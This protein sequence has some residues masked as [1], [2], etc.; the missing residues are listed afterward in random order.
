MSDWKPEI[1]KVG[2]VDSLEGSDFLEITTVMGV[3]PTIVRKGQFK[4]GDLAAW[5]PYDS[6]LPNDDR[7]LFL[8][9][10]NIKDKGFDEIPEKYRTLKSRKIRGA[11]SEG[12]LVEAPEGF[13]EGD[14]I[15]DHFKLTKRVYKEEYE[16][17][18]T[19]TGDTEKNPENFELFKYDLDGIAKYGY[20]FD[21]NEEVVVQEKLE[22]SN[23][24]IVWMN[25]RIY[26]RS[27]NLF[28]KDVEGSFWWKPVYDLDLKN[29]L[30]KYPS[31]TLWGE[32]L[33]GIKGYSYNCLIKN[34]IIQ[35][36][37]VVFD[38]WDLKYKK[39]LDWDQVVEICNDLGVETAPILYR[40]PWQG[41]EWLKPMAE[42]QSVIGKC[43]REGVVVRSVPE[44]WHHKLGRKILKLKGHGYKLQKG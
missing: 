8:V 40:G 27:R 10:Q 22:G 7:W 9:P 30:S 13:N 18:N 4:E 34:N 32:N 5:L 35:R 24:S 2:K 41:I 17:D 3:Y 23:C 31:L 39:F 28:K 6:V 19:G 33:G 14:C 26:V 37:F 16:I 21:E 15:I 44:G 43:V 20:V 25:D 36:K 1:V 29:K 11:Y 12:L 38:I 42:G